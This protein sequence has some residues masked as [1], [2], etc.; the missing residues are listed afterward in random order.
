MKNHEIVNIFTYND[1]KISI[2]FERYRNDVTLNVFY[3]NDRSP[4]SSFDDSPYVEIRL[5]DD[6]KNNLYE[7]FKNSI[8]TKE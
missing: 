1:I 4:L 5:S 8:V 2:N 3:K 6:E 7:L